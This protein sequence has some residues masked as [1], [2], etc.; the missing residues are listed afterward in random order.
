MK[1]IN[2]NKLGFFFALFVLSLGFWSC[3][4]DYFSPSKDWEGRWKIEEAITYPQK[5]STSGEIWIDPDNDRKLII[6]GELFGLNS[7]F[8]I[9]AKVSTTTSISYERD[10]DFKIEGTANLI[11]KDEIRFKFT[12]TSEAGNSQEFIRTA[13][14]VE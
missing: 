2:I 11:K 8:L 12:Y 6:S 9:E 7:S 1:S 14:R 5:K 4:P 3:E 10:G 13:R